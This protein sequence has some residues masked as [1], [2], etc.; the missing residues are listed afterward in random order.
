MVR[1]IEYGD[2]TVGYEIESDVDGNVAIINNVT[3]NNKSVDIDTA[4]DN[5]DIA[6]IKFHCESDYSERQYSHYM[7]T[8]ETI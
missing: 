1:Y 5:E 3:L 6:D 7:A 2:Y 4:F 8:G